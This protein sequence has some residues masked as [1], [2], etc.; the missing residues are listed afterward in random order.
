M[1]CYSSKDS[2]YRSCRFDP[3]DGGRRAA[4]VTAAAAGA[5]EG[6]DSL[7]DEWEDFDA[8]R[9]ERPDGREVVLT[10]RTDHESRRVFRTAAV[11]VVQALFLCN[12]CVVF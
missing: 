5:A 8:Q 12:V 10:G 9:D 4:G 1:H 6:I 3:V 7:H 11:E 2:T